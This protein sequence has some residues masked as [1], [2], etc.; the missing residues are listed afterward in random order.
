[1]AFSLP[2][3]PYEMNALEPHI[4]SETLEF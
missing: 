2:P 1:M 4:S 3:L